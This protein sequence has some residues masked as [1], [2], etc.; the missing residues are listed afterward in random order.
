MKQQ[1]TPVDTR[2]REWLPLAA[3]S[4]ALLVT[5]FW[6]AP[7]TVFLFNAGEVT[8]SLPTIINW[9]WPFQ[10]G[11][12]A[13]VALLGAIGRSSGRRLLAA[14]VLA[15]TAL[16]VSAGQRPRPQL[17]QVRRQ[18]HRLVAPR[19]TSGALDAAVW[20]GVLVAAVAFRR[21]VWTS[22]AEDWLS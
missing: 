21:R 18:R 8:T 4:V 19:C 15:L 12:I 1:Q 3:A 2:R 11:L 10:A 22:R 14:V 16:V 20:V 13:V 6:V 9:S 17:R 5:G 7:A